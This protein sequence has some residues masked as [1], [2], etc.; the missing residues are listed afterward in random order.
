MMRCLCLLCC[1][2]AI[3]KV[4]AVYVWQNKPWGLSE[5]EH[6]DDQDETD[7]YFV[8]EKRNE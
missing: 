4:D 1:E 3:Y 8:N 2:K 7:L 6:N 5:G